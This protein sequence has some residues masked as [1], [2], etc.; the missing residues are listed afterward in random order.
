MYY[1]ALVAAVGVVAILADPAP[2]FRRSWWPFAS[3]APVLAGLLI[4]IE[5]GLAPLNVDMTASIRGFRWTATATD[6]STQLKAPTIKVATGDDYPWDTV[7]LLGLW[8]WCGVRVVRGGRGTAEQRGA[9]GE[10][11]VHRSLD[12]LAA[13][14][15]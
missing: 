12:E 10:S 15:G 3:W 1:D 7:T 14:P 11:P 8:A 6:G 5:N 9:R 13:G 2:Y 4:L